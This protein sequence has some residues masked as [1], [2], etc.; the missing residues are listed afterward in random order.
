MAWNTRKPCGVESTAA[1]NYIDTLAVD[2]PSMTPAGIR[3]IVNDTAPPLSFSP[4]PPR[5]GL[6]TN[7]TQHHTHIDLPGGL[8]APRRPRT[9]DTRHRCC[10]TAWRVTRNSHF[11][12]RRH[13]E[14][15]TIGIAAPNCAPP[16]TLDINALAI[17]YSPKPG[18]IAISGMALE[19]WNRVL[20]SDL[21]AGPVEE[22]GVVAASRRSSSVVSVSMASLSM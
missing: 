17:I 12:K 8:C 21:C 5:V 10:S 14:H 11:I 20:E 3:R 4:G 22:L 15:R 16:S 2:P 7:W 9:L 18:R 1:G 13:V 19:G 6:V